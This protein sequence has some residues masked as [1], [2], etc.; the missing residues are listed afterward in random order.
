MYRLS[1][2]ASSYWVQYTLIFLLVCS[3]PAAAQN[4]SVLAQGN[5]VKMS[6]DAPGVYKIDRSALSEMGF[7]P[8]EI[9][10]RNIAIYGNGGGMLPQSNSAPR[11]SDLLE[12][13]IFVQGESD[14][15]F[16]SGDYILFYVDD[17]H[18]L[19]YD[20]T[21]RTFRVEK[22][23]YSD[24]VSYFLTVKSSAG[25]RLEQNANLGSNFPSISTYN[26]LIFHEKDLTNILGSGRNWFGER[27]DSFNEQTFNL[28]LTNRDTNGNIKIHVGA[29]AQS[30]VSS[31]MS[32]EIG[33]TVLG[34]LNFNAIPNARYTI[35]GR[36]TNNTFEASL[37]GISELPTLKF[38][39]NRNG[40]STGLAYL[41][42]FLINVPTELTLTSGQNR[43]RSVA[44]LSNTISSFNISGVTEESVV[45][46]VTNAL[47]PRNQAFNRSN[48]EISFGN[49]SDELNEYVAF[50]PSEIQIVETFE[51]IVNQDLHGMN[52]PEF[53]IITPE[54]FQEQ[55]SRLAQF[56]QTHDGLDVEVVTLPSLYNE[57]SSGQQDVSAIRD[58][59]RYLWN[60][61]KRLKYVLL[62]GK[63]SYDYKNRVENN[64]NFVPTYESRNSLSP[65]GSYSSDD[66]FGFL[67][68]DEGEWVESSAGDHL[69]D[70]GLGRIP[71]TSTREATL[72]VNKIIDYQTSSENLGDWRSKL[73]FV[74]D[75][76]DNNIH[77]RDADQLA[78]LVDTTYRN[79]NV[80]KIYLDA[81]EQ[82]RSANGESSVQAQQALLNA[83]D[84][85][86]LILNFTGH[87]AETGWMQERILTLDLI[88]EF[89]NSTALPLVVTATCEF[90]RN[91]D[92]S[93][94]SGAER[95]M[96]KSNGGAVALI[97][98]ARPVFSSTNYDLNL[99]LYGSILE[100]N[101]GQF[102]RLGDVIKFTK[103]NSLNGSLNRNFILLG[104]P[105][106]RLAYP[107]KSISVQSIN[108]VD[109]DTNESD[110]LRALQ[111]VELRGQIETN[112][113]KDSGF[114]GT[115][116]V[117]LFDKAQT[118]RTLGTESSV[119]EFEQRDNLIFNG[120]ASVVNGEFVIQFIVP[121]NIQYQFGDGKISLYATNTQG[122]SDAFGSLTNIIIGGT[123]SSSIID[124]SPPTIAAYLNDTTDS[125]P[126]SITPD[127]IL[128]VKIADASGINI[129]STGVGQEITAS[130]NES[131]V[132]NLNSFFTTAKDDFRTGWVNFPLRNLPT[133]RNKLVIKA[134]DNHNNSGTYTLEFIVN[135]DNSNV[136]MRVNNYPNP[137]EG[138]TTFSIDHRSVG[139]EIEMIV[140]IFNSRGEKIN[141]LFE[142]SSS[143]NATEQITWNGTGKEGAK[144]S[145]GIYLYHV[146][147]RSL[148][149]GKSYRRSQ[150][151]IISN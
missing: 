134:W 129:S 6:F 30:F 56:R 87:G 32:V 106:M 114:N 75:D 76:G 110:T 80:Q 116:N 62:F 143:A 59:L 149:T 93:I 25:K 38:T 77:Q 23:L 131:V 119:F 27:F 118:R 89:S 139:E 15:I 123:A 1:E 5:W 117:K 146:T 58:Y 121:R 71:V 78:T 85:G 64:T 40:S 132:Y 3:L 46:D 72:A 79:F 13:A 55:A 95:I 68:D 11:I 130:L 10:P 135:I 21:S 97:T 8:L 105:S 66:F 35:K 61:D 100:Q 37:N 74:A 50:N 83:V 84:Q 103:N 69:L 45:W 138:T 112:G 91:D 22:N 102:A 19:V 36:E 53:I 127:A 111:N 49:F 144:L 98:T 113:V 126:Y 104:D 115:V 92:P 94:V 142:S 90:G 34:Q 65:L 86:L 88:D 48:A 42:Y 18:R 12:N 109:I 29:M 141:T 107:S 145:K 125:G 16:N 101:N 150:K 137:F 122:S 128:W 57:F 41:D 82:E 70:I 147:L 33:N 73:L 151:L 133:G 52:V 9:N 47:E 39:Y 31:S 108:G 140:E 124:N 81:F 136:I 43:F 120:L 96:L 44:S 24:Q 51:P 17:P 54:L 60:R 2:I 20:P 7:D 4:S 26:K 28:D 63:G 148:E 14:G 67:E 99:A